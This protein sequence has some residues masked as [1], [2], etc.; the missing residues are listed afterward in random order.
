M[1]AREG[2]TTYQ[3]PKFLADWVDRHF[4]EGDG[5]A[6]RERIGGILSRRFGQDEDDTEE[7]TG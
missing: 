4:I 3:G 1:T 6:L 5:F 7:S 2:Q